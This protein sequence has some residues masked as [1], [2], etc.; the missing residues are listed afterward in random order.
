MI[1]IYV[2]VELGYVLICQV[3]EKNKANS[4]ENALVEKS[5]SSTRNISISGTSVYTRHPNLV[6][7]M[8]IE[9]LPKN[10][11]E[12]NTRFHSFQDRVKVKYLFHFPARETENPYV[13]LISKEKTNL[14]DRQ[15]R[16]ILGKESISTAKNIDVHFLSSNLQKTCIKGFYIRTSKRKAIFDEINFAAT[17][18]NV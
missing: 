15:I 4:Y 9:R 12:T 7:G 14:I 2:L 11:E 6:K 5:Q 1:L 8:S 13:A 16:G 17:R 3:K 18:L 10:L